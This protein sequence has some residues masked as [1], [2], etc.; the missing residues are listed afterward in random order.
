[1]TGEKKKKHEKGG[2]GG[3]EPKKESLKF[4]KMR[5]PMKRLLGR[6]T[7]HFWEKGSKAG[8]V[9]GKTVAKIAQ[10]K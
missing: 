2:G 3:K 8:G 10:K 4:K 5:D 6:G 1:L 9:K 7:M